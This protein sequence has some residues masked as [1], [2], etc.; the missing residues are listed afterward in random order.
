MFRRISNSWH[1]V[2]AS[3]SVLRSDKEL[4]LF[5]IA[6][7][8]ASI[9]VLLTFAVP[10]LL[11]DVFDSA[12]G[13]PVLGYVIGFLFYA[14]MYFVV[15]FFNTALIGATMIRLKGG[16]PT[17]GDG[18]R[19]ATEHI[20]DI[21]GYAFISATVGMILQA[22]AERGILGQ[23]VSSFLGFTWGVITFLVIPVLVM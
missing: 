20:G 12:T 15:I 3:W 8:F 17:L 2:K 10:T 13:I 1:L 22:I 5:P 23:L 16:D 14:V 9:I 18:L 11:A 6:S 19:I 4:I 21:L 7:F